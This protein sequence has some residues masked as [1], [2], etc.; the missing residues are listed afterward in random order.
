M[1]EKD[2]R[3]E[4]LTALKP[5]ASHSCA[6]AI[7]AVARP[8]SSSEA[9]ALSVVFFGGE[10]RVLVLIWDCSFGVIEEKK[11]EKQIGERESI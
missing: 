5:V 4:S 3:A 1:S 8:K 6:T 10:I 9:L 7:F 2:S 11:E